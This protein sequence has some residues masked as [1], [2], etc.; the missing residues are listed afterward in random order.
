MRSISS[1]S[2]EHMDCTGSWSESDDELE[3]AENLQS[4]T[5]EFDTDLIDGDEESDKEA[6][7]NKDGSVLDDER[8][9]FGYGDL[10]EQLLSDDSSE[11]EGSQDELDDAVLGAED[12]EG[13]ADTEEDYG[14]YADCVR[15]ETYYITIVLIIL[16]YIHVR[17]TITLSSGSLTMPGMT[18][19]TVLPTYS[20]SE[21]NPARKKC[22]GLLKRSHSNPQ[23]ADERGQ[24]AASDSPNPKPTVTGSSV[25][26]P[27]H[28][29]TSQ[30]VEEKLANA[31]AHLDGIKHVSGMVENTA[32]ASDNLQSASD[33][34]DTFSQLLA[35]LRVFNSIV[36]GLADVH[37]YAK[38]AL[39][40]FTFV[41]KISDIYVL[42]MEGDRL[43]RI[44]SMLEI[45]GKIVQ[46]TLECADFV[47]HYSDMQN[48]SLYRAK[49]WQTCLE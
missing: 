41:S 2:E 43:A 26:D 24:R 29:Q 8:S 34:I 37:P 17:V 13:A 5:Y 3:E 38:V 42:L 6:D 20:M 31:K 44:S 1:S 12:G 21:G 7:D 28:L 15:E 46:Q 45:Y 9:E 33:M 25:Q 30:L 14:D 32:S 48:F 22:W 18:P 27:L 47:V 4:A 40:I 10:E 11:E 35:P 36:T 39:S 49:T 23:L 19:S 16:A